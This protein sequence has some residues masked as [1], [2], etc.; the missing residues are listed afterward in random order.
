ML[1]LAGQQKPLRVVNDQRC[2]PTYTVDLAITIAQLIS[3]N[4][5]GLI[6]ITNSGSCTW[7]ELACEIF[8]QTQTSVD[9][10]PITS[11]EFQAAARRPAYSV[12]TSDRIAPL[13]PWQE[14]LSA[15]LRE[16]Q[17]K[18]ERLQ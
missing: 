6:H 14:A 11:Q 8:R 7:Y 4:S 16:R 15:Y 3:N 5:E 12:L 18:V 17:A 2:T 9:I 13:R 1:R 10:T